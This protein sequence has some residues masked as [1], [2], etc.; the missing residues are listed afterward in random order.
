MHRRLSVIYLVMLAAAALS[1]A[2][3]LCMVMVDRASTELFM[4]RT[5]D[6]A[7]F[8]SLAEQSVLS[9]ETETLYPELHSYSQLYGIDAVVI[10]AQAEL[11]ASSRPGLT[12]QQVQRDSGLS[13][14]TVADL[15]MNA[16]TGQRSGLDQRIWPWT[17]HQLLIAEPITDGGETIGAVVTSSPTASVAGTSAAVW[18]VV[19]IGV[20]GILAVGMAA[21]RPVSQW[22]LRPV[23]ELAQAAHAI[24]Q[25]DL[26][27]RVAGAS[28]PA[29]LK[30]LAS[31]FNH[32][33]STLAT[34]MERQSQFVAYAAHQIRNPLAVVRLRVESLGVRLPAEHQPALDLVVEELDRLTRTCQGLLSLAHAADAEPE[35]VEV[36]VARVARERATAWQPIAQRRE[37]HVQVE[38]PE[39]LV[40]F[41]LEHTVDQVLDVLLD[42]ALKFGG[43]GVHITIW[44]DHVGGA[45]ELRVTDD[46]P[47]LPPQMLTDAVV[48]FWR[49]PASASEEASGAAGGTGLGL[50]AVVALVELDGGTV[51]LHAHEPHGM[52][53]VVRFPH[54]RGAITPGAPLDQR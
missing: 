28:G 15:V 33:S 45:V 12:V 39:D 52:T 16:L 37:A 51:Q 23:A 47:G 49:R 41:A 14:E 27:A 24:G 5:G 46:G 36:A 50:S 53:A 6:A 17:T 29:E 8:A 18:T 11:V 22:V 13:E 19:G 31:A 7:R 44:A 34:M 48:P 40:V 9:G 32:M 4:D 1:L 20:L 10:D 30:H 35:R 42:N 54:T 21:A 43:E 26:S 25:G 3:P 2:V 38:V